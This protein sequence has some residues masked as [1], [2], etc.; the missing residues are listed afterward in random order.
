MSAVASVT[1]AEKLT[2]RVDV[3]RNAYIQTGRIYEEN[4][5]PSTFNKYLLS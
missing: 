4:L 3:N 2:D 1:L 5:T